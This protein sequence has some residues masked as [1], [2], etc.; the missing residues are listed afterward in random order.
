MTKDI[1]EI[2]DITIDVRS[3]KALYVTIGKW[4]VYIDDSTGENIISTWE[5]LN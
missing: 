5:T 4:V 1:I 2:G 3:E